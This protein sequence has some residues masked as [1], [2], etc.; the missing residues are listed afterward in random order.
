MSLWTR[1]RNTLHNERL[2][3]EIDE[4]LESHVA[5]AIAAGRNPD[6]A[7]RACGSPLRH[8]EASRDARL[9]TWL[10]A[11]CA[12]AIFGLRQLR[13]NKITS[14]AAILSLALAMGLAVAGFRLIDAFLWRP[15]PVANADRLYAVVRQGL[16][17]SG[18]FRISDSNEYPLFVRERAAVG[19]EA[20]LV[21]VSFSD[22]AELT[23]QTDDEFERVNRQYV[24]GWMF[25]A[26]GL[27]PAAGRL[28]TE[29]DDRTPGDPA[30]AVLS[31]EY[32]TRRFGRDPNAVGRTFRMDNRIFT[33]IGVSPK[34][35]TGT[36]PGTMIDVFVPTMMHEG[37]TH[38]DWSWFRTLAVMRPGVRVDTVRDKLQP[39]MQAFHEERARG[40]KTE[41]K[42]FINRF[43]NQNLL[44][45]PASSGLSG[46]QTE[47]RR[48][49]IVMGLLV[50][51]VLLIACANVANLMTAQAAARQ[52]EMALR[53]SIGA[54][55][56][57][58]VQLLLVE[59]TWIAVAASGAGGIFAWWAAPFIVARINPPQT[60][61]QLALPLDW[62]VTLFAALL[63]FA[64]AFVCALAPSLRVSEIEPAQALKG[65]E[66][67]SRRRLMWALVATQVAFCFVIYFAAGLFVTTF[68][69]LAH[70]PTG[71]SSENLVILT[72]SAQEPQPPQVWDETSERLRHVPGVE[73]VAMSGWPLLDGNGWNGFIWVNGQATEVLAYFL[74]VSPGF[75]DTMRIPFI[76]GRDFRP[77]E[78][79]P[80]KAI[81]NEAFVQ[82][83]FGGRNP[84]GHW[85]EK[86]TGD[87]VTRWR[88]EVVGV[89]GNAHY[90]NQREPMTPTAY[91]PFFRN[92][93]AGLSRP[94]PKDGG[95]FIVR[96]RRDSPFALTGILR[97]EVSHARPELRVTN[98]RTQVE[99]N[100]GHTVRERLLAVL[101]AFFA[102]V[103]LF[104]AAVGVYGVLH[105]S[106][107][108][109]Q[110]EIG[111]RLALGARVFDIAKH[112]TRE[113]S[114]M[115][116]IGIA[117]GLAVGFATVRFIE[118]LL[119]EVKSTDPRVTII[120]I[121]VVGGTAFVAALPALIRAARID[122][123]SILRVE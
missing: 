45:E 94:E 93:P 115:V 29:D 69:R 122:P 10:D 6:E 118:T 43:L 52:R 17:P 59:S 116:A 99:T 62:R 89:V 105:Y 13:K 14:A 49:L 20:E 57:R 72:A 123:A 70:Q 76:Q 54:G 40:F 27:R 16:G 95:S 19:N 96:V 121:L 12:D 31:N 55:R 61:A 82:Q 79:F 107:V 91:V 46:M 9:I 35:F 114:V 38:S 53:I 88:F 42:Q 120:P 90:R 50:A 63:N 23:Y 1:L 100:D 60:P 26:F 3:R 108:Q 86:E 64:V 24:S 51:M 97:S 75:I 117:A 37:V 32:W 85:F 103:G 101:A 34:G 71:Y 65:E 78:K 30:Y 81:V 56:L 2:H 66:R 25:L 44:L 18:D 102:A 41:T 15:L 47:Y 22:R 68:E 36:E 98:I 48:S 67:Q 4:E 77:D 73:S 109:R 7:R 74:S 92:N 39:V 8:R 119:Y 110:K 58:L 112:V 83:C 28:F 5:E 113:M 84:L 11:L 33:V 21:A 111:V 106:V 80:G 87:G 104:L